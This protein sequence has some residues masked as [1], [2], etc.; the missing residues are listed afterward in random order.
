MPGGP[1]T[2]FLMAL[3][4]LAKTT[5]CSQNPFL[6]PPTLV[7]CPASTSMP[8][9][10]TPASTHLVQCCMNLVSIRKRLHVGNHRNAGIHYLF[11][12]LGDRA[13]RS[14]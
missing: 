2:L 7:P 3:Q 9:Q 13:Y 1:V 6:D 4:I 10:V 14:T 11:Q 8:T 12:V 5:G